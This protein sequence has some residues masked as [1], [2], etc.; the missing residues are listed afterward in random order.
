MHYSSGRDMPTDLD[1]LQGTWNVT[2]LEAD[3]Q[4]VPAA[5][6]RGSRV[7]I[8]GNTF[9]SLGMGVTYEGTVELD[10]AKRP[11]TFDLVFTA[12]PEKG[13][14][15]VGIYKLTGGRWTI[16][17][18]TR[19]RTRPATFATKP[20]TG[21]AL[22]TLERGRIP[23]KTAETTSPPNRA[24]G[25]SAGSRVAGRRTGASDAATE[26]D[27]E[28]AMI[29]A[30]FSGKALD[31]SMV[32]W[33]KRIT[34]GGVTTVAAGA[35]VQVKARFNLDTSKNP[36]AIDYVNLEGAHARKAQAG[37]VELRGDTLSICMSAPGKPRPVDFSSKA[38][39]GRSYTIWRR[40]GAA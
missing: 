35:Q 14:R 33:C 22:E 20:G 4:T 31:R 3:G 30:V 12:G 25:N 6:L 23:R 1:K 24:I 10:P 7:V 28:W 26:I 29:S 18:A 8:G 36:N 32:K 2:S 13:H 19:G 5:A 38:G 27:G 21:I 15:N 37:I 39:D 34:R 9:T 11:K 16:C 40:V 17:L